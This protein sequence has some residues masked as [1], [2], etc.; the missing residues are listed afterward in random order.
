M[1]VLRFLAFL[2][3]VVGT[4]I[5]GPS[6]L[7]ATVARAQA[8][9]AAPYD[10]AEAQLRV[11][12]AGTAVTAATSDVEQLTV[13]LQ[14]ER[15][16]VVQTSDERDLNQAT[17]GELEKKLTRAKAVLQEK[18]L[19]LKA[20]QEARA[21]GLDADAQRQRA[22]APAPAAPATPAPPPQRTPAAAAPRPPPEPAR[23]VNE[24]PWAAIQRVGI[25]GTWAR[26]CNQAASPS[27]WIVTYSATA[28]GGAQSR[29]NNGEVTRLT[30]VDSA[31]VL[32]PTT[33]RLRLRYAYPQ[34]GT[35]NGSIYDVVAEVVAKR[36]RALQSIRGDGTALIK[37]GL[38]VSNGQPSISMEKCS[39]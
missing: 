26:V 11:R 8:P 10:D 23:P 1:R 33:I 19:A 27:N 7:I 22:L 18:Q 21:K 38:F 3:L 25:V 2:A 13:A 34:W 29:S 37:D 15:K 32:T 31:Q 17:I 35:T 28:N 16:R 20:A 14:A 39:N 12:Q 30:V 6:A 9:A 4:G 36:S 5:A 24:A